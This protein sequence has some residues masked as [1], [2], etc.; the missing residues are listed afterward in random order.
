MFIELIYVNEMIRIKTKMTQF[1]YIFL[2]LSLPM[3]TSIP[4]CHTALHTF[5]HAATHTRNQLL[6]NSSGMEEENELK[7]NAI[8]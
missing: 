6:P 4:L 8:V 2:T 5:A 7:K 3:H 1:F